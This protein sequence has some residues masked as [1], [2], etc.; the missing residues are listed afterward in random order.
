MQ[1]E[2]LPER[3]NKIGNA[4][5]QK[6]NALQEQHQFI[7]DIRSFGAM[8]AVELVKDRQTK[9][10]AKEITGRLVNECYQRGL[11]ILSAGIYSNVLRGV[12]CLF[13]RIN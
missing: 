6:L 10:P 7:G 4:L 9:E 5:V 11:I 1:E 8:V 12:F 3:A 2:Q 13:Y